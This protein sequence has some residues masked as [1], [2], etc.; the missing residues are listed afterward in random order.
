LG[1]ARIFITLPSIAI[2]WISTTPATGE[3]ADTSR[4]ALGRGDAGEHA[5]GLLLRH[6]A[7][8]PRVLDGGLGLCGQAGQ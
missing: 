2:S 5:G 6:G 8:D 7:A 1:R 3:L 4:A